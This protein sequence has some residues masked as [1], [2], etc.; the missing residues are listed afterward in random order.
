M[1]KVKKSRQKVFDFQKF[2]NRIREVRKKMK[3]TSDEL[4]YDICGVSPVFIRQIEAGAKLPSISIFVKIC[5]GLQV[6]PAYLFENEISI[7][8]TDKDWVELNELLQK[9][10]PSF[11]CIVSEVLN[12]LIGNLAEES[13]KQEKKGTGRVV[14]DRHEFARRLAKVRLEMQL[15]VQEMAISCKVSTT[16][17]HQLESGDRLPSLPVLVSIC[18]TLQISPAYLLGNELLKEKEEESKKSQRI[19][20][21]MTSKTQKVVIDVLT[22]LIRELIE[23]SADD[24]CTYQ[25]PSEGI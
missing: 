5:N 12:S 19:S 23:V 22:V 2:G 4:G 9:V 7:P 20:Y 13:E 10:K 15:T 18:K 17:I 16:F 3:I 6:S 14:I 11:Q 21:D 1:E 8:I 25:N 24:K